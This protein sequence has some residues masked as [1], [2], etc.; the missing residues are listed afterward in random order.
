VKASE[1]LETARLVLRRPAVK[2]VKTMFARYSSDPDVTRFLG[3]PRHQSPAD[4]RKFIRFSD[5]EW[6]HWP[7]GP[8]L[9]C[10][11]ETGA[12]LGSTG[13][14]FETPYRAVTGYALAKDSWGHGYATEALQAM[15]EVARS[16]GV[17]RLY[18]L[19][20]TEHCAS[21][22]VLEKC[23]FIREG[24]LRCHSEFPNLAPSE[25]CDV[26]CYAKVLP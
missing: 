11:R 3:W 1:R 20:H 16:V 9:V 22:R 7:A 26:L 23:G 19:C 8:Y 15:V 14:S 21:W 6:H 10:S 12:L 17:R 24:I 2:D 4:T 5:A 13:L 25:I 18:A